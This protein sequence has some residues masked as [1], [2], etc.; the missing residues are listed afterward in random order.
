MSILTSNNNTITTCS[1]NITGIVYS[2]GGSISNDI[3]WESNKIIDFIE[4]SLKIM[5]IELTYNQFKEM[6]DAE[7]AAFIRDIKI[8]KIID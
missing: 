2:N 4:F 3:R 6:S 5:G 1:T 7:K 8:N